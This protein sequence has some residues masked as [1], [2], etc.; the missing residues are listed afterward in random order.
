MRA[1]AWHGN[2]LYAAR[3][4][5][6]LRT[7]ITGDKIE[8]QSLAVYR[9]SWWRSVTAS[10]RLSF[11]MLRDGFHALAVLSSGHVIGAVAG[12]IVT[13]S[14]GESEFRISQRISR[15]TR[16]LHICANPKGSLFFGEYFD[17]PRR[18]E[19]NI[20][21]S[22]DYGSSWS[23]CYT[24]AR[25]SVRHIHNIAYDEWAD[26]LWVL[27]GDDGSECRILRASSDF[28]KVETVL[29]GNQQV[30]AVAVI[31][32]RQGL[33]FSSD[34]PIE[35]NYIYRLDRS[36]RVEQVGE[37]SSSSIYGCRVGEAMFFST[38]VEPSAIN[39]DQHVR[40]FASADGKGWTSALSWQKDS[41]PMRFFQYGNAFLPDGNN[42]SGVLA[43]ST[44]AVEG[45]DLQTSLWKVSRR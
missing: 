32:T 16:P 44:I 1:L 18:D 17:N 42:T 37:L 23:V 30:R 8:W 41:W 34:T 35:R 14:P 15:G 3:G 36:D 45:D 5:E 6:L 4:Y 26:C 28:S 24:F 27:T 10:S 29:S 12:A 22:S 38:M 21:G 31:P 7:E 40:L 11:R 20:Y 19:V 25:G 33:Y 2:V 39:L 9:P 43:V 13:L